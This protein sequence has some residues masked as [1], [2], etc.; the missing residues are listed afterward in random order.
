MF[1]SEISVFDDEEDKGKR[2]P[3]TCYIWESSH[4]TKRLAQRKA[5]NTTHK[6]ET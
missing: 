1:R 6:L 3:I 2:I 4:R 5:R